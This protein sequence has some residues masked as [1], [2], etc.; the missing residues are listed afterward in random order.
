MGVTGQDGHV[1]AWKIP[2]DSHQRHASR[3]IDEMRQMGRPAAGVVELRGVGKR[4]HMGGDHHMPIAPQSEG[5][6]SP[7]SSSCL[8]SQR[9]HFGK[10]LR[11]GEVAEV[12][13]AAVITAVDDGVPA[14]SRSRVGPA[15]VADESRVIAQGDDLVPT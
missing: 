3:E 6:G 11:S 7:K 1:V 5:Q 15:A 13:D 8:L 14:P 2:D 10:P 12:V 9:L 4:R